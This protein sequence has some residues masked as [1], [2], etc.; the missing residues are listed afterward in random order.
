MKIEGAWL[1]EPKLQRVLTAL[2]S[3]G[4]QVRL[5]GGCVR[6]ALV[7]RAIGD[8]DLATTLLP[9]AVMAAAA[10][11]GLKA[12]PT[13][14][15]HGT[16][17]LVCE[18]QPFEVTTLR[19]DVK[20]DGR[21]A[22]VA[23]TQD[24]QE[25]AAR[26]DFTMNALSATPDGEVFDYF[27]GLDDL[28]VGRVK[29]VG[30]PLHRIKEDVLRIL[31]FFRFQAHF[32]HGEPDGAALMA[33]GMLVSLLPNLSR[34]RV[35]TEL[36]KLLAAPNPVPVWH[37]MMKGDVFKW[38]ELPL[39]NI[40]RLERVV[41]T[42]AALDLNDPLRRLWAAGSDKADSQT[43]TAGLRLSNAEAERLRGLSQSLLMTGGGAG[44]YRLIYR[45]GLQ[46]VCDALITQGSTSA[47]Q[48]AELAAWQKPIFPL[49]GKDLQANGIEA[50]P[51][52]GELLRHIED[53]WIEQNFTPDKAACEAQLKKLL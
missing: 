21:H 19:R 40:D 43:L 39:G 45:H 49:T 36:L 29:F 10:A 23:F 33:T 46:R 44:L 3:G 15:Q 25:D 17:T 42:E 13:G 12:V 4:G 14:L 51:R 8:I 20:T 27:G 2:Q 5:V 31:R 26:R 38:L 35:R 48:L 7:G 47:E 30:N 37:L 52:M 1:S 6:D 16:V 50:G 41:E 9:E 11:A 22:E 53:W 32:G 34:E 24:W 28:K 18:G